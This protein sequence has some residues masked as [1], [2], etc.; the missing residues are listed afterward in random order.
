VTCVT[1]VSLHPNGPITQP[2][3]APSRAR[4]LPV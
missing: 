1:E 3:W 2:D 4:V